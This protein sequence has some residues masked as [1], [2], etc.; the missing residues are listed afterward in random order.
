MSNGSI[1]ERILKRGRD[2]QG[3]MRNN[4]KV[5]DVR[6][7]YVDIA[8]GKLKRTKKRGFKRKSEAEAFLLE[9][10]QRQNEGTFLAP[11]VIYFKDYINSW[12]KSYAKIKVKESTYHEYARIVRNHL[13]PYLGGIDIKNITAMQIDELYA[14][15]LENGRFDGTGGLSKRSVLY[16]HRVL[17]EAL[18]HAVKKGLLIKNPA[19]LTMNVP[20]PQKYRAEIYDVN[21]F[22]KLLNLAKDTDLELPIVLAGLCGLRRGE[23]LGLKVDDINFENNTIKIN[24]QLVVINNEIKI[25]TPK[26]ADSERIISA[27]VEVFNIIKEQININKRNKALLKNEYE[28]NGFIICKANAKP[29]NPGTFTHNFDNFLKRHKLKKIR[30]HDLRH[31]CASLMLVSGIPMKIV[32]EILGHSTITITADLY[33]HVLADSKKI[34]AN[35][36]S[37]FVFGKKNNDIQ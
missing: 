5:Y 1:E 26:T 7:S 30:F 24:K 27:P 31:S 37:D 12:L 11:K 25:S 22:L 21:E 32:S 23:C 15:L 34:A 2:S 13:I 35:Q 33:T 6:Y 19:K 17:N 3:K 18:E 4:L 20:K 14:K 8:I 9:I 36:L 10:N 29:H 28:D 16:T